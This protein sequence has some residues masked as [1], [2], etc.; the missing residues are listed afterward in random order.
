MYIRNG[1]FFM[2]D[3]YPKKIGISRFFAQ[4]VADKHHKPKENLSTQNGSHIG[5]HFQLNFAMQTQKRRQSRWA[6]ALSP[7]SI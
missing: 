2:I 5:S 7:Y 3:A 1:R 4:L 6:S